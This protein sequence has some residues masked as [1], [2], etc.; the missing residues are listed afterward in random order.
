MVSNIES[1]FPYSHNLTTGLALQEPQVYNQLGHCRTSVG[2]AYM[3]PSISPYV[4]KQHIYK[5][6]VQ[7]SHLAFAL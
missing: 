1:A 4:N 6:M 3:L 5:N 2:I 7:A